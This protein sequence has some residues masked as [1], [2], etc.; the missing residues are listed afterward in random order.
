MSGRG[1]PASLICAKCF[2]LCAPPCETATRSASTRSQHNAPTGWRLRNWI[3]P[4]SRSRP[5][6]ASQAGRCTPR[7]SSPYRRSGRAARTSPAIAPVR[8]T[9]RSIISLRL[10][11]HHP[12]I[13]THIPLSS[14]THP[15]EPAGLGNCDALRHRQIGR[16]DAVL[17]ARDLCGEP[18]GLAAG[19]EVGFGGLDDLA[20]V[21]VHTGRVDVACTETNGVS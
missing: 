11:S 9:V 21:A 20:F 6:S 15:L 13:P 18:N 12:P 5:A 4:R 10:H 16:A 17:V 7:S 19:G 8:E 1:S 14:P 2:S 3:R